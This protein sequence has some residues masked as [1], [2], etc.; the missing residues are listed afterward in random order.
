M[1]GLL[2][3]APHPEWVLM[4]RL[5]L[6]RDRIAALVRAA[7]ATVGYHLRVARRQDPDLEAAHL[8]AE[9]ALSPAAVARMEEAIAWVADAGRLPRGPSAGQVERS[10]E[11]WIRQRRSEA[12]AGTLHPSYRAG[13]ARIA[14]WD[15]NART[16]ADEARWHTRLA[17]LQQ[18]R[19]EG[20]DWPR[21]RAYDTEQEHALGVWIHG[22]RQKLREDTLS[23]D[24]AAQL[25]AVVPGWQK[26]RTRG[27][28]ARS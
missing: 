18:Y 21:H 17:E 23:P 1:V 11:A 5:G 19:A 28:P 10:M 14:G 8:A 15:T 26:G 27:R 16:A 13:L 4:Y 7:P 3:K 25:D 9:A 12:A 2:R 22:Q 24:K 20:N 6:G